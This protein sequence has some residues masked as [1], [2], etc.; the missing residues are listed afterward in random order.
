MQITVKRPMEFDKNVV[1]RMVF[2][3]PFVTPVY[4][5]AHTLDPYSDLSLMND[6]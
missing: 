4:V 2:E 3:G 6:K 1:R 5:C